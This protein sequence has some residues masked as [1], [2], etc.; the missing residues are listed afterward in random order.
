[1]KS[2]LV[3]LVFISFGLSAQQREFGEL[4]GYDW[5]RL[6]SDMV[7]AIEQA[8]GLEKKSWIA[9]VTNSA[10]SNFVYGMM[11]LS[12]RI[13]ERSYDS[14]VDD[15]GK[16]EYYEAQHPYP[17]FFGL[18]LD[19]VVKGLDTFYEDYRNMGVRILDA[20]HLV[21][22]EVKGSKPD[23]IDWQTRYYRA[24]SDTRAIMLKERYSPSNNAVT[25]PPP[26]K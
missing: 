18:T 9:G 22:M 12:T 4:N 25:P 20:I 14:Y 21:R 10:K 26:P 6:G 17:Y 7:S 16:K 15:K 8:T 11:E 1:M 13:P 19:Q 3:I 23:Q 2:A 5:K 24:D